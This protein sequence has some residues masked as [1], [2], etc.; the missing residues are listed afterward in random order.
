LALR[1]EREVIRRMKRIMQD[2]LKLEYQPE[3]RTKS[4]TTTLLNQRGELAVLFDQSPSLSRIAENKRAKAYE[5]A[6]RLA[7]IETGLPADVFPSE[8]PYTFPQIVDPEFL[9]RR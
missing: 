1:D 5:L 6:R 4:W 9:P 7:A 8:C 3:K 2:L